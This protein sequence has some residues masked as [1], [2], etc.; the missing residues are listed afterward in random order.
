MKASKKALK[1]A[2]IL[3]LTVFVAGSAAAEPQLSAPQRQPG[4]PEV[5]RP[6]QRCQGMQNWPTG[7]RPGTAPFR[8]GATGMEPSGS[9]ATHPGG[10]MRPNSGE[11]MRPGAN[12]DMHKSNDRMPGKPMSPQNG[13][14]RPGERPAP[15]RPSNRGAGYHRPYN[16]GYSYASAPYYYGGYRD[17][18]RDRDRDED[19]TGKIV[20]GVIG[21]L[22]LGSILS[23]MAN[24]T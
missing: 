18:D 11:F 22:I 1:A 23:N 19:D 8:R 3:T 12:G 14:R 10:P 17:R 13:M 2:V 9:V 16:D 21:G 20:L 15:Q 24:N 7:A 4:E 6:S 5:S